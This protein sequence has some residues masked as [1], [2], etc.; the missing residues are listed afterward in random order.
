MTN[1]LFFLGPLVVATVL[2]NVSMLPKLTQTEE[3]KKQHA[4]LETCYLFR[5]YGRL[6]QCIMSFQVPVY[7][8]E[9]DVQPTLYNHFLGF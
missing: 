6:R 4:Y 2:Q 9:K 8:V 7:R 1:F 3:M 5:D